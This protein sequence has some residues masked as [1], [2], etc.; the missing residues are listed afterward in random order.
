MSMTG[1]VK[2]FRRDFGFIARDDG[3]GDVFVHISAVERAG[4]RRLEVG[5]HLEFDLIPDRL[6]SAKPRP[7]IC[8]SSTNTKW[9]NAKPATA[10]IIGRAAFASN[11]SN[12]KHKIAD[13]TIVA[14]CR[15]SSIELSTPSPHA[16]GDGVSNYLQR[17]SKGLITMSKNYIDGLVQSLA[18]LTHDDRVSLVEKLISGLGPT[19][20]NAASNSPQ[21]SVRL[22]KLHAAMDGGNSVALRNATSELKRLGVKYSA[23]DGVDITSLQAATAKWSPEERIRIKSGLANV[24]L[25]D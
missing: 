6:D 2:Q 18:A 9:R 14:S 3:A 1:T 10:Y 19:S 4:L 12:M 17:T 20:L 7:T 24:G 11:R 13:R 25:M 22:R 5:D 16:A 23:E 8:G 21:T 15:S